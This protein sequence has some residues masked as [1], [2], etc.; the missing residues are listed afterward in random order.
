MIKIS[1]CDDNPISIKVEFTYPK[2][3]DPEGLR[4][5][6]SFELTNLFV[7]ITEK[8]GLANGNDIITD[9]IE[10]YMDFMN[11]NK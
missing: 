5:Y 7:S 2:D 8:Y 11:L 9:A 3:V 6:T 10:S 1:P 4:L